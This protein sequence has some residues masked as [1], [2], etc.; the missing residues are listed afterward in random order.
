MF[1]KWA[2]PLIAVL[3]FSF[4]VRHVV[5]AEAR[6]PVPPP[7]VEP[8]RSPFQGTVAATGLVEAR[9]ENISIGTATA[10][11]VQDIYVK[12]GDRVK[13]GDPLFR[14]DERAKKA[15][16]ES[17]KAAL[18]SAQAKLVK[19]EKQPRPE[20][21]PPLE[22]KFR[23]AEAN[24]VSDL[25]L[26]KRARLLIDKKAIS[27]EEMVVRDQ[28]Y[29]VAVAQH[30]KAKADLELLKAGTWEPDLRMA[31]AEVAVAKAALVE[32]QTALDILLVTA[33]VDGDVMQ[34]N[35]RLGEYVGIPF[36]AATT[37][38]LVWL[39]DIQHLHL[40]VD[41]DEHDIG[42]FRDDATA[43]AMVRGNAALKHPIKFVRYEPFVIPKKSLTGDTSERV[44]TRVLQVIFRID[45]SEA[46]PR[47]F[48]G[49]Q[50]DV[51]IEAA[52]EKR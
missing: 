43:Y 12:V 26:M 45:R 44:D 40:R 13:A 6:K 47:L 19:L 4:A 10:G 22:A 31:R 38:A 20:E 24:V 21:V 34:V 9:T 41:I 2:L 30:A 50:M 29:A 46:S 36:G 37:T 33:P 8:A 25:D 23:E 14:I 15:E 51:F 39:G 16:L 5:T 11:L 49:Q 42:R 52:G 3:A 35:L 27:E 7:P 48:V 18:E 1:T 28:T 17:R 32:T